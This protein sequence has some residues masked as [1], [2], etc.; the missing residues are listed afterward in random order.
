MI[1]TFYSYK[2]G[3]GR[4]MALANVAD[5]LARHGLKV[6]MIDFDLEAPGLEQFFQ[7]NQRQVRRHLGLLDLLLSYKSSMSVAASED[8]ERPFRRLKENFILSVYHN[9]P[10]GGSLDLMP[11]GQ[12]GDEDQ[13]VRYALNLRTFDWQ[14]FYFNWAGETFFEWL[15]RSLVPGL[16]DVV[17]IDSRTGVTEIGGI[18]AYQLADAVVMFC[19]SNRQN[20]HGTMNVLRDFFSPRVQA[21]RANRSL[22]AIVVPARVEQ[23]DEPLLQDFQHRFEEAFG[24]Y[25]PPQFVAAGV[26]FWD[27]LIPHDPPYAFEERV[28]TDPARVGERRQM[29][30]A[31]Q[32][33]VEAIALLAEPETPLADLVPKPA[34]AEPKP[35]PAIEP[36][37][38]VTRRFAVYDAF[39][40]YTNADREAVEIV[41][42]R[43]SEEAKLRPFLDRWN[44]VPGEPWQEALEAAIDG[45]RSSIIFIGPSGVNPWQNQEMRATLDAQ[46]R[47]RDDY[48]IIPVLLPGADPDVV[49]RLLATHTWVDLRAGLDDEPAFRQ[50]VAGIRGEGVGPATIET[51][52]PY[53]GL[54]PFDVEHAAFFFG[55]ETMVEQLLSKIRKYSFVSLVGPS[56]CGKSSLVRAGLVPALQRGALPRSEDWLVRFF[57]PGTDPLRTLSTGLIA[58]LQ[59]ESPVVDQMAESRK[60]ADYLHNDAVSIVDV[61]AELRERH[62]DVHQFVLIADQFEEIYT[63][64]QVEVL[65]HAFT[66]AL[67]TLAEEESIKVVLTLRADFFG[68]VLSD[69]QLGERTDAGIVNVLPMTR[70]ELRAAIEQPALKTGR[71]FEAG[72]VE[73]IL[74]DVADG[75]GGLPLLQ[76]TLMALWEQ[77]R[78]GWLTHEGYEA[79]GGGVGVIGQRAEAAYA[80]LDEA[81]RETAR[82]IFPR[83]I[84]YADG[85]AETRRRAAIDDLVTT[86][87]SRSQVEAVIQALAGA[88]LLITAMDPEGRGTVELAHDV[89]TTAWQRLQHWLEEDRAFGVWRERLALALRTWQETEEDEGSLLRGAI[90]S[91]AE[92]WLEERIDDL[93]MIERTF[94]ENSLALR[95]REQLARERLRRRTLF[96]LTGVLLI[97]L[98]LTMV[99]A[100]GWQSSVNSERALEAEISIRLTAQADA[101]QA[102]ANALDAYA[103]AR[104]QQLASQS[105][106]QL[107]DKN[108]EVALLLALQAGHTADTIEALNASYGALTALSCG[109]FTITGHTDDL[110]GVVWSPDGS[111]FLT[112]SDDGTA[113]AW[114]SETR[115]QL[116]VLL[117]HTGHVVSADWSPDGNTIL[118][119]SDD[120]TAR[121][122][123]AATG[124]ELR[125]LVGHGDAVTH[126]A[127]SPD[128]SSILTA[129]DDG[130]ARMWDAGTGMV[131]AVLAGHKDRVTQAAWSPDGSSILTASDDSTARMWDAHTGA[132]LLVIEGHSEGV[133]SAAW[134]PDRSTILTGGD[135]GTARMWDA[136]TG[137]GIWIL[138]GHTA[139]VNH[140]AWSPDGVRILTASD[141]GTARI[142]DALT[143]AE[144]V[145]FFGSET[146][147]SSA[148]WSPDARQIIT[149]SVDGSVQRFFTHMEDVLEIACQCASRNMTQE[150]WDRF[151]GSSE[152]YRATCDELPAPEG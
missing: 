4:S 105:A 115:Q 99:A 35:A 120:G 56:G 61:A 136:V 117:G 34:V 132:E 63:E 17:L 64:C 118:A 94:L 69:R 27:L 23:R 84:R 52:C 26:N 141:D 5:A 148:I 44:L 2:G 77:Q 29:E 28:I 13:L 89:L 116:V 76:Y 83:L 85:T 147:I 142:W 70:E 92:R 45:S 41:A 10:S 53:R 139:G 137:A 65:R 72:L 108:Y 47:R 121:M 39:L 125:I 24:Q 97:A 43:L 8:Q 3:V 145:T 79:I 81:G 6:L 146:G 60:L 111:R 140:V 130:T 31:F 1:C 110:Y 152:P 46:V 129:S 15:R 126:I 21:R 114:D 82:R 119:A 38:D 22:S 122:W 19:A 67:L 11:A 98:V 40:A 131:L 18:C 88:R 14:D 93:N 107:A 66:R 51:V 74:N 37:Y 150:E 138:T 73:R 143:G 95:K 71:V 109:V 12:R 103:T 16:Y 144:L 124:M 133:N 59:P 55:R 33:L 75:P 58:L 50:L 32:G 36:Q 7:I 134:S 78:D 9:L 100:W 104:S 68:H 57:R 25:T 123:D 101:E 106:A 151:I 87:T 49:P 48:R 30:I 96:G 90:L 149:V 86:R 20:V 135:D 91:E 62:P 128:G 127:W 80:A 113:R 102:A 54:E 42:Q 112:F